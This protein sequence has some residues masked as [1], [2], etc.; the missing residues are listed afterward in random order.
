M[1]VSF[2]DKNESIFAKITKQFITISFS[3]AKTFVFMYMYLCGS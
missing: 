2:L 3:L 1:Y